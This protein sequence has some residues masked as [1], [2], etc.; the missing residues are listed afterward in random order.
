MYIIVFLIILI[1]CV[2]E[3]QYSRDENIDPK[4]GPMRQAG[5]RSPIL[6]DPV[7]TKGQYSDR[8]PRPVPRVRPEAEEIA[9][10]S[11]G[12]VAKLFVT[13][14]RRYNDFTKPSEIQ[15]KIMVKNISPNPFYFPITFSENAYL[16]L[17]LFLTQIFI[18]RKGSQRSWQ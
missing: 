16:C 4:K 3:Y 9:T 14:E 17:S 2:D 15:Y 5:V 8:T 6:V 12:T 7:Y 10:R 18:H 11:K 1:F 13:E